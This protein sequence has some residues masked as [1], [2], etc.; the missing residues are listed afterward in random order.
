MDSARRTSDARR[1]MI[2]RHYPRAKVLSERTERRAHSVEDGVQD[3]DARRE[4]V[5][6][7]LHNVLR[8]YI[9]I[10]HGTQNS[11]NSRPNFTKC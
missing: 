11:D 1:A 4:R 9:Y 3:C 2:V 7:G 8:K 5:N 10:G 6:S